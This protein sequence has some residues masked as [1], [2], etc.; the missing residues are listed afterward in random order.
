MKMMG[1][2]SHIYYFVTY[3]F[4]YIIYMISTTV[5]LAVAS[6]L[7]FRIFTD[8]SPLAI[9]VL[10]FLWGH[11]LVAFSLFFSVF[12]TNTKSAKVISYVF[13]FATGIVASFLVQ[14]FLKDPSTPMN[15]IR[16]VTLLPQ[17]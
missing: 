1:L 11:V 6:V 10:F 13:V 12:F 16:M 5:S 15:T 3:F 14:Q 9:F 4:N 8:N 7:K 2:K 17:V